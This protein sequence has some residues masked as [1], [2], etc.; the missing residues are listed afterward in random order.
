RPERPR[1]ARARNPPASL[2]SSRL[3]ERMLRSNSEH[4]SVLTR[5]RPPRAAFGLT[6]PGDAEP[7][8]PVDERSDHAVPQPGV[9]MKRLKLFRVRKQT[10]ARLLLL[11]AACAVLAVPAAQTAS[12]RPAPDLRDAAQQRPSKPTVSGF[13]PASGSPGIS[14]TVSGANFL[15]ASAVAFN[16][17]AAKYVIS[18]AR[19]ITATVPD[20]ATS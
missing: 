10:F 19:R 16:G 14:V 6:R 1:R 12:A 5:L 11:G 8:P 2:G 3:P 9:Q 7:T 13:S 17:T 18:S 4:S 15:G 20:N